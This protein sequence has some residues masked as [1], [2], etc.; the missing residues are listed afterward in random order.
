[1]NGNAVEIADRLIAY[2]SGEPAIDSDS[3]QDCRELTARLSRTIPPVELAGARRDPHGHRASV[4]RWVEEL[5]GPGGVRRN[6]TPPLSEAG[7]VAP[8]PTPP[9]V[10]EADLPPRRPAA[11]ASTGGAVQTISGAGNVGV[12]IGGSVAGP[13]NVLAP[14]PPVAPPGSARPADAAR[15]SPLA[16]TPAGVE[17]PIRILFLGANPT[18]GVKLR[19]DQEVREIDQA[20]RLADLGGRFELWQKWA[21]RPSDLQAHLLRCR[22]DILHFSGH[23]VPGRAILLEGEDGATRSVDAN[24]LARLLAQFNRHLRCVFLNACY[25]EEQAS[26]IARE[27]DCVIGMSEEVLDRA[28]IRFAANFYQALAF[29]CS[30]KAAFELCL[31]DIEVGEMHQDTIPQLVAVRKDPETVVFVRSP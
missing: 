15:A 29:G 30:V 7:S 9:P 3:R 8:R 25:S 14:S 11:P 22:P 23:G 6:L 18:D 19:L 20:L 4:E 21:V 16:T 13:V 26:A 28:A 27:V 31:A 24:R 5:L 2:W 10:P 17:A 12:N 1:M